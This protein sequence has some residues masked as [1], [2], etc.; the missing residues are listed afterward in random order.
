MPLVS[1][2]AS[3][4]W[5]QATDANF[6][7]NYAYCILFIFSISSVYILYTGSKY[8]KHLHKILLYTEVFKIC[9]HSDEQSLYG[10]F[11]THWTTWWLQCGT[12]MS[13]SYYY[14]GLYTF[15]DQHHYLLHLAL[16]VAMN[17][18][19]STTFMCFFLQDLSPQISRR[20]RCFKPSTGM[21]T[22]VWEKFFHL[23][24]NKIK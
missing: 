20:C 13:D 16:T 5:I 10:W 3:L 14:S 17:H 1:V 2:L 6:T 7:G 18:D 22:S 15:S 8:C 19:Y 12:G 9:M 23:Q 4:H 24:K 21:H 11:S